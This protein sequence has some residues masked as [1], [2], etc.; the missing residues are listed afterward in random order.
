MI[1]FVVVR[2]LARSF[3]LLS[4]SDLLIIFSRSDSLLLKELY[5]DLKLEL[6]TDT[7]LRSASDGLVGYLAGLPR[8]VGRVPSME[9]R[10]FSF[11]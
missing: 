9:L 7:L 6:P 2:F 5:L 11:S 1:F 8:A 3:S 4:V 10:C